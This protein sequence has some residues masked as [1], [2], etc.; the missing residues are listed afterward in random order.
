MEGGGESG[1]ILCVRTEWGE[2]GSMTGGVGERGGDGD[3]GD[4]EGG[5]GGEGDDTV[6]LR[7]LS[8]LVLLRLLSLL[9]L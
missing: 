9:S 2:S 5:G 1:N 6:I 8:L 3:G 4:R 7:S